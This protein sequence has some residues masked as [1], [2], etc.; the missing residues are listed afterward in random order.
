VAAR[1]PWKKRKFIKNSHSFLLKAK[2][3]VFFCRKSE[4]K[5]FVKI[6][7]DIFKL[8]TYSGK[9]VYNKSMF[10]IVK[11][12]EGYKLSFLPMAKS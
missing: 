3:G 9:K 11:R 5:N 1:L 10:D 7:I 4:N 8:L 12:E 2:G 6:I